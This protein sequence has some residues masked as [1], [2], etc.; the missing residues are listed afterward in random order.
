MVGSNDYYVPEPPEICAEKL[1]TLPIK[2]QLRERHILKITKSS[3]HSFMCPDYGGFIIF[4]Q[5][6]LGKRRLFEFGHELGHTYFFTEDISPYRIPNSANI[7][8]LGLVGL[9]GCPHMNKVG[10][11]ILLQIG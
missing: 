5:P 2:E 3:T 4:V 11:I 8:Q 10:V 6:G 9:G 1:C 7:Y